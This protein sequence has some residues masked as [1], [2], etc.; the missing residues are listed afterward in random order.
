MLSPSLRNA[1]VATAADSRAARNSETRGDANAMTS[2]AGT[3]AANSTTADQSTRRTGCSMMRRWY[4]E[5]K[6]VPSA[7]AARSSGTPMFSDG[8]CAAPNQIGTRKKRMFL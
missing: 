3:S 2:R 4:W 8:K 6:Q 1:A 7:I 5:A